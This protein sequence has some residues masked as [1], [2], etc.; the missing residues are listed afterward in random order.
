MTMW[1]GTLGFC[2]LEGMGFAL[3]IG[4]YLYLVQVNPQWPL[5][6][7]RRT[8]GPARSFLSSSS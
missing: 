3:A 6:D 8:T 2:A 7:L 5:A 1:W 4:A